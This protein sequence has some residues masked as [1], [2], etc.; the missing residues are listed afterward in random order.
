MQISDESA[1]HIVSLIEGWLN[2]PIVTVIRPYVTK[3]HIMGTLPNIMKP[4]P[5][6]FVRPDEGDDYFER[7]YPDG[8]NVRFDIQSARKTVV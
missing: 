2:Q 7:T 4:T 8:T 3:E 6:K 1:A 5:W